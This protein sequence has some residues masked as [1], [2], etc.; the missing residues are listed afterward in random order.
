MQNKEQYIDPLIRLIEINEDRFW[1]PYFIGLKNG[2]YLP[3]GGAGSLN[4]WGP[5]YSDRF[6]S[7]WYPELY[8]ILRYLFDND[9]SADKI[10]EF[11]RIKFKN[12]IRV[13]RCLNCSKSYQHPSIFESQIA[14]RFY[15]RNLPVFSKNNSLLDLFNPEMTYEKKQT[16]EFR[17]WLTKQ[18]H[19]N[20]IK[21]YDF[22]T[23][24]YICPHCGII[25]N[26]TEHDL[27]VL[28]DDGKSEMKF[29]CQKRNADWQDF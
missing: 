12:N 25:D 18:F 2:G 23:N 17:K 27:Y 28:K 1:L 3:G 6:K 26:E 19:I 16:K 11:D 21:I 8:Y 20:D 10:N 22:V 24:K 9:L 15:S 5:Y 14:T 7:S 4:D 29:F 13:I